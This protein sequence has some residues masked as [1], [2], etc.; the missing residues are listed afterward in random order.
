[1]EPKAAVELRVP[2]LIASPSD[3]SR[4]CREMQA[5]DDYLRDRALRSPGQPTEK[6]PKTTR[7][8][9][10]L[11]N[12]NSLN[13][14]DE[15][16]RGQLTAFL[17]DMAANAPVVHISFAA[18]PSSAAL[19]KVVL[20]FRQNV[21][22]RILVRVGLQPGIAAGCIVRTTNRYFDCSLGQRLQQSRQLLLDALAA[23]APAPAP[24]AA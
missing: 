22:P 13:L 21:H 7:L 9:D 4:L 20:W 14:L 11:A 19:Q 5:L 17:A 2:A 8:L 3:V 15:A 6:L 23:G 10:E 16:V 12:E 24:E 18:D 1:M